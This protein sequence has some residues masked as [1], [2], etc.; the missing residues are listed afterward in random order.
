MAK[1]MTMVMMITLM[2]STVATVSTE[3]VNLKFLKGVPR[4]SNAE[5]IDFYFLC[6]NANG[7]FLQWQYNGHYITGFHEDDE[8]GY[9]VVVGHPINYMATLLS[10]RTIDDS[11]MER[12][13]I[14]MVSFIGGL[15]PGNFSITCSNGPHSETVFPEQVSSAPINFT[16]G[17]ISGDHRNVAAS[18]HSVKIQGI[19]I[20]RHP[21]LITSVLFVVSTHD[22]E[23]TCLSGNA[24]KM[25]HSNFYLSGD[26]RSALG[27][28]T[29]G[30]SI[31]KTGEL[32]ESTNFTVIA[33]DNSSSN[34]SRD[35]MVYTVT[36]VFLICVIIAIIIAIL[37]YKFSRAHAK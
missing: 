17:N 4:L 35:I 12:N 33:T 26:A 8:V 13:S 34:N 24:W 20:A 30:T 28:S 10:A 37:L 9:T 31:V 7:N 5:Y 18:M 16:S 25:L 21:F 22:V 32:T 2:S 3:L 14:I 27:V 6:Y 29:L 36:G 23:V 15:V 19:F 11:N 1:I